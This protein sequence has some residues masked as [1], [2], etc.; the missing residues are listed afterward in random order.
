MNKETTVTKKFDAI[1]YGWRN[2][3][4]EKVYVGFH[5]TSEVHDGYVFSSE[6]EELNEAWSYGLLQRHIIFRGSPSECITLENYALKFAKNNLD[7]SNF[8]NQSVGGG[9]GCIKDFSNLS[10]DAKHLAEAFLYGV[11]PPEEQLDC[12]QTFDSD[13]INEIANNIKSGKYLKVESS[14]NEIFELERNQVR[15][16]IIHEDKVEQIAD[17]M[18]ADPAKARTNIEPV[19]VCVYD[20]GTRKVIDGNHTINAAKRAGWSKVDVV[21]INFSD[22]EF[23]HS[24]VNAFGYE[25]NHSDKIKTPNS[26]EDCQR[27]IINIYHDL[28]ERGEKVDIRSAKF[29]DTVTQA[30]QQWWTPKKIVSNLDRAKVRIATDEAHA[31]LNFKRWTKPELDKIAREYEKADF[32]RAVISISSGTSYNAGVG[33]ILNK[34]AGANTKRGIIVISHNDIGQYDA[35]KASEVKLKAVIASLKGSGL[36]IDYTVLDAFVK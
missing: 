17:L 25:M 8:Y 2:L 24:N 13:L 16:N 7:W 19:V 36:S 29:K 34:M 26:S 5:K 32:N 15:M 11:N 28:V 4:N 23:N 21:F 27:A 35:W 22:F 31:K 1:V 12:F 14:V 6:N 20:N 18:R 9:E 3:S 10:E 30:L 33:A